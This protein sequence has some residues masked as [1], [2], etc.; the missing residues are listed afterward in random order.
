MIDNCPTSVVCAGLLACC[1]DTILI[2]L[3]CRLHSWQ[4]IA[5]SNPASPTTDILSGLVRQ[6]TA[7][8]TLPQVRSLSGKPRRRFFARSLRDRLETARCRNKQQRHY[9]WALPDKASHPPHKSPLSRAAAK[10][11]KGSRLLIRSLMVE[12]LFQRVSSYG[13]RF[14]LTLRLFWG[15]STI[16]GMLTC[17][18]TLHMVF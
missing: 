8:V 1:Q 7:R 11:P 4:E 17:C 3:I 15:G 6:V 5:G 2:R 9:F 18:R 10:T 16:Y 13:L 14:S 12:K